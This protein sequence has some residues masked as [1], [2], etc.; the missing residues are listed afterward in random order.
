MDSSLTPEQV[1]LMESGEAS[2]VVASRDERNRPSMGW[3]LSCRVS[4]DARRVVVFLLE[5]QSHRALVD[6]RAR[7]PVSLL[8]TLT[9]TRSLQLKSPCAREI[10]LAA[11]DLERLDRYATTITEAWCAIGHT[12]GFGR[13]LMSR[14]AD[15]LVAFELEPEQAFDQTPG[16]RAGTL[17]GAGR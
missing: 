16:P 14:E 9:S 6:L 2:I 12:E 7:R 8:F 15:T 5:S 10:P 13:A 4:P 3:G 1:A 11:G 17:V